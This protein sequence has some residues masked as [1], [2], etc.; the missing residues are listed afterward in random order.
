[1]KEGRIKRGRKE[2]R[3]AEKRRK[4]ARVNNKKLN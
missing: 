3:K 1:M 2:G 4:E